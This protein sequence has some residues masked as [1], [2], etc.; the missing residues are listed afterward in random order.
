MA[1]FK[2]DSTVMTVFNVLGNIDPRIPM[3][4]NEDGEII[5]R[6][7]NDFQTLAYEFKLK[8]LEDG[9]SLI[10]FETNDNKVSFT[11]FRKFATLT[12][13][14]KDGDIEIDS[15]ASLLTISKAK[16]K[17]E[18]NLADYEVVTWTFDEIPRSDDG[19]KIKFNGNLPKELSQKSSAIG[20]NELSFSI[21]QGS[22]DIKMSSSE[23]NNTWTE[24]FDD[25]VTVFGSPSSSDYK[26][27][28]SALDFVPNLGEL[29]T[30]EIEIHES[31][32]LVLFSIKS[33]YME[34]T[35][36]VPFAADK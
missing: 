5:I 25:S 3:I 13:A 26:I 18:F 30:Y 29:F 36:M 7:S 17:V 23:H 2:I 16:S 1:K 6:N 24:S 14:L 20:A 34:L 8:P 4:K 15:E 21:S 31:S 9:V 35:L 11:D 28:A 33:D 22:V 19:Y 12:K 27:S 32:S 10:E